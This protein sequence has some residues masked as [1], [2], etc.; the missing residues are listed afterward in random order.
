MD[1]IL[2]IY[3][4]VTGSLGKPIGAILIIILGWFVAGILK[5][6]IKKVI[7][8]TGIDSK[9]KSKDVNLANLIAKLLY[10]LVMIFVFMLALDKLGLTSVLEPVKDLL[11]GFTAYIPS[12]I[13]G[14]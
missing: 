1:Q 12:V 9:I 13:G 2:Q 3:N 8:K 10:Y 4:N 5:N 11:N 7:T 6:L 14:G